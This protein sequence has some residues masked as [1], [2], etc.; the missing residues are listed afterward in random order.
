M[1]LKVCYICSRKKALSD[2]RR[3]DLLCLIILI[4]YISILQTEGHPG[5]LI[6]SLNS[7]LYYANADIFVKEV[8]RISRMKP[9]TAR[10]VIKRLGSIQEFRRQVL[11][12]HLIKRLK[13]LING[14]D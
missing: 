13:V 11:F 10:K 8:Y 14:I 5:I 3:C 12:I 4:L 7:P 9:K 6:V 2:A 1:C